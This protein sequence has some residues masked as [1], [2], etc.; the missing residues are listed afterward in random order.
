MKTHS[1]HPDGLAAATPLPIPLRWLD[2]LVGTLTTAAMAISAAGVLIALVLI[3]YAVFSRYALGA[4]VL[5]VD[6]IVGFLL[7]GIVM[8]GASAA[9]RQGQHIGVDLFTDR[10]GPRAKRWA[11]AWSM[12]AVLTVAVFLVI[13]GWE[14][15]MFSKMLGMVT[16]GYVEVPLYWLQLLLPVGGVMLALAALDGLARLACGASAHADTVREEGGAK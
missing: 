16:H 3:S 5:W 6:S 4:P 10:L 13:D 8:L 9:L 15:A 1:S 14:T 12:L 2:G 11:D 7:V